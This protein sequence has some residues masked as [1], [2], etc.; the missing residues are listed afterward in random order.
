VHNP[1]R[2]IVQLLLII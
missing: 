1:R 2:Q